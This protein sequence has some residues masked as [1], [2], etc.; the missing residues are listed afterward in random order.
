[1]YETMNDSCM[2]IS[3]D[4]LQINT[5]YLQSMCKTIEGDG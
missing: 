1:M 2:N 3:S 4:M 5:V